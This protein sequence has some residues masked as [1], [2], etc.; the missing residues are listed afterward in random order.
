M[1]VY[2]CACVCIP[3]PL[4]LTHTHTHTHTL[5]HTH[6]H[7]HTPYSPV[8]CMCIHSPDSTC[9]LLG[10]K[11]YSTDGY[12]WTMF[13]LFPRTFRLLM[14]HSCAAAGSADLGRRTIACVLS[15]KVRPNC[16]VLIAR[17]RGLLVVAP[18][19][20]LGFCSTGERRPKL[21]EKRRYK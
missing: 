15:W 4:P 3:P 17:R 9:I 20:T 21:L 6:T 12:T 7:T 2:A 13:P 1:N 14:V 10:M 16:A 5:T 18:M 11:S 19:F 8:H